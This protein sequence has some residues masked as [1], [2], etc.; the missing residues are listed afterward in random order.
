MSENGCSP[1]TMLYIE[2]LKRERDEAII[3]RD[4]LRARLFGRQ[5]DLGEMIEALSFCAPSK[6]VR[7]ED[8]RM[9]GSLGSY[10]GYYERLALSRDGE[11]PIT[12][13]ALREMLLAMVGQRLHGYKGGM[14][15]M[16]AETEMHAAE[17][18]ACG[19]EIVGIDERADHVAIITR[20]ED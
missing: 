19:D 16:K 4:R 18:G 11:A 13:D 14:Y 12:A 2:G 10:R 7:F 20:S 17:Y 3:E 6:P 8:G 5:I 9:P 15:T 1:A